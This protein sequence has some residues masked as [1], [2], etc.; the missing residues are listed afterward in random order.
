MV[1]KIVPETWEDT[2]R[3]LRRQKWEWLVWLICLL[4]LENIQAL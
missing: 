4:I 2:L 3:E 1:E